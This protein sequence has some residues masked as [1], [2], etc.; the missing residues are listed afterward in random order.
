MAD[1]AG[2]SPGEITAAAIAGNTAMHHLLLGID[3]APLATPPYMPAVQ[4]ALELWSGERR[5]VAQ[6]ML[7]AQVPA[8]GAK[9]FELS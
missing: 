8:H 7:T 2:I 4:E 6:G 1:Q 5:S 3:P 9:L